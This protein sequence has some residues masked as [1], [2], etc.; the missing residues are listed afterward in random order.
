MTRRDPQAPVYRGAPQSLDP[1]TGARVSR[2]AS[3]VVALL[4]V[5]AGLAAA[6]LRLGGG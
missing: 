1:P 5:A 2:P 3:L 4:F 6:L